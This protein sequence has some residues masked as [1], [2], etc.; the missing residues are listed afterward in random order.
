MA[1][2]YLAFLILHQQTDF[3]EYGPS[4][5]RVFFYWDYPLG[6]E[7]AIGRR[8]GRDWFLAGDGSPESSP[9]T[10]AGRLWSSKPP[11]P[12]P[13]PRFPVLVLSPYNIASDKATHITFTHPFQLISF[14]QC[15][16][17]S[18]FSLSS[19]CKYSLFLTAQNTTPFIHWI[20]KREDFEK[21]VR[22]CM[23]V[24]FVSK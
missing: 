19:F 22:R 12:L 17:R 14:G 4:F 21:K 20:S 18:S 3:S 11:P 10:D 15:M 6:R 24:L 16:G 13:L 2:K 8:D 1:K 5:E 7:K 23:L 9:P